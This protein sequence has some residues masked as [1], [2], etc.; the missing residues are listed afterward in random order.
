MRE[1]LDKLECGVRVGGTVINLRYADDNT[2]LA[3][4]AE[5]IENLILAVKRESAKF[6]LLLN[7]QKTKIMNSTLNC[8]FSSEVVEK[9]ENGRAFWKAIFY[10]GC[11]QF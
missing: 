7:M 8:T 9:G 4:S 10:T 5:D 1:A 6:G 3:D 11:Y 2:F